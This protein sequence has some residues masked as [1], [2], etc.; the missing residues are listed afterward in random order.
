MKYVSVLVGLVFLATTAEARYESLVIT[1]GE[2]RVVDVPVNE[3]MR[4]VGYHAN[5]GS[6]GAV[7]FTAGGQS[8]TI[9]FSY[10]DFGNWQERI[11]HGPSEVAFMGGAGGGSYFV[12]EIIPDA[13][14]PD[15]TVVIPDGQGAFV[16]LEK[17]TDLENWEVTTNGVFN[18]TND[19]PHIFFRVRADY[20]VNP[21]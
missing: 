20:F 8:F 10:N 1:N 14:G 6:S 3:T 16:T 2:T 19:P 5:S 18:T 12:Y 17:S 7:R 21:Q 15:R 11:V 4:I 13:F 9:G